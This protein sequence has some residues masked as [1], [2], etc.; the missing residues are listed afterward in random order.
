MKKLSFSHNLLRA[1]P[2]L[3]VGSLTPIAPPSKENPCHHRPCGRGTALSPRVR[4]AHSRRLT[5]GNNRFPLS[6]T[7]AELKELRVNNNK[8]TALP[9]DLAKN[10]L[11]AASMCWHDNGVA[12]VQWRHAPPPHTH[13]PSVLAHSPCANV[14]IDLSPTCALQPVPCGSG[15][16][17][18]PQHEVRWF[19][20]GTRLG[21]D[22]PGRELALLPHLTSTR[23]LRP[24][25][26][27][28]GHRGTWQPAVPGQPQS[29]GQPHCRESHLRGR[30]RRTPAE[31][32]ARGPLQLPRWSSVTV[33]LTLA[34]AVGC[35]QITKLCPAL[36]I[37]DG[38]WVGGDPSKKKGG[39][40]KK[41][42]ATGRPGPGAKAAA[43]APSV[44]AKAAEAAQGTTAPAQ[45]PRG[46]AA[47]KKVQRQRGPADGPSQP[48]LSRTADKG[49]VKAV[50]AA[51]TASLAVPRSRGQPADR[52]FKRGRSAGQPGPQSPPS[53]AAGE[54]RKKKKKEKKKRK[55][56]NGNAEPGPPKV[57]KAAA[58]AAAVRGCRA[59]ANP[60][61]SG[62]FSS[63]LTMHPPPSPPPLRRPSCPHGR[64]CS[65]PWWRPPNPRRRCSVSRMRVTRVQ[66]PRPRAS[67]SGALTRVNWRESQ[68][69]RRPP[70]SKVALRY[71]RNIA[72]RCNALPLCLLRAGLVLSAGRLSSVI[73]SEQRYRRY[74]GQARVALP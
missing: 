67:R 18:Y 48:E 58:L 31:A 70:G 8:I 44:P 20:C 47:E 43:V 32:A 65:L 57:I 5:L 34:H 27:P 15:K 72:L 33:P 2:N 51:G 9:G 11:Y 16:Q 53:A 50:P 60:A 25:A 64:R 17:S 71:C 55:K 3:S 35:I 37:L 54:A 40:A 12:R 29:G 42:R 59:Y 45:Q 61:T 73:Y 21:P 62:F 46:V 26:T 24:P 1:V 13:A 49:E 56:T 68:S 66:R 19:L 38:K 10:P 14:R 52:G 41:G 36:H 7:C 22:A 69:G 30:G 39:K 23:P 4:R 63:H 74:T 6:Q 28:Q